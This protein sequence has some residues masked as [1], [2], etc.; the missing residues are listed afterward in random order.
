MFGF[1]KKCEKCAFCFTVI[2]QKDVI[3]NM[4]SS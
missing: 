3:Q 1:R 4:F 2:Y